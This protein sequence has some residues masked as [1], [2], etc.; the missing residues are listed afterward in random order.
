MSVRKSEAKPCA[1][2][3][4][5][6]HLISNRCECESLCEAQLNYKTE[7]SAGTITHNKNLA[8]ST[9]KGCEELEKYLIE[10]KLIRYEPKEKSGLDVLFSGIEKLHFMG[11]SCL[12]ID[13]LGSV[14]QSDDDLTIGEA[15]NANSF[16]LE[17]NLLLDELNEVEESLYIDESSLIFMQSSLG[18]GHSM[19]HDIFTCPPDNL[20]E[21]AFNYLYKL[22]EFNKG[23]DDLIAVAKSIKQ[24]RDLPKDIKKIWPRYTEKRFIK[25][26]AIINDIIEAKSPFWITRFDEI[27]KKLSKAQAEAIRAEYFHGELEKPTQ[28]ENAK[29][30]GISIASY[31]ERLEWAYKKLEKLFPEY[32]RVPRR[33][34]STTPQT[35]NKPAPLYQVLD[36]GEKIEI[37]LPKMKLKPSNT[38]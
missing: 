9:F 20:K 23:P 31:Q 28:Q 30:L 19:S 10:H 4:N 8:A 1:K 35:T 36:S 11:A 32:E 22:G 33:K 15:I 24:R 13:N 17:N 5:D 7:T 16:E 27:W 25:Y 38:N 26:Q 14:D 21:V 37:P 29:K 3:G 6:N 2:K 12:E 18:F 34:K